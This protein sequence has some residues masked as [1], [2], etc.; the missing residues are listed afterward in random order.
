MCKSARELHMSYAGDVGRGD[1]SG[2]PMGSG[3]ISPS[4]MASCLPIADAPESCLT[5]GPEWG[6]HGGEARPCDLPGVQ[7][8]VDRFLALIDE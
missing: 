5:C 8:E 7:P 6:G 2:E 3:G 1:L 4:R